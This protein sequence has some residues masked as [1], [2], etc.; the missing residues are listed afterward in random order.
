MSR[1]L[2]WINQK[3]FLGFGCSR[4]AWVFNSPGAPAGKSFGEMVQNFELKRDREFTL[5]VCADYPGAKSA[6][7]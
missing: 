5:H 6:K 7:N 1:K 4:C 3:R 2:V